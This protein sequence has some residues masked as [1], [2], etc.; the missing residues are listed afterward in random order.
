MITSGSA[1]NVY[2]LTRIESVEVTYEVR[3]NTL[4]AAVEAVRL[5]ASERY[6][7]TEDPESYFEADVLRYLGIDGGWHELYEKGTVAPRTTAG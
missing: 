3:A 2:T 1:A 4:E 7:R 5:A 6:S